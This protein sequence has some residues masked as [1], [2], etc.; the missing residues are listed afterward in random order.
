MNNTTDEYRFPFYVRLLFWPL[1]IFF[2]LLYHQFAWTYDWVA[3]IVSLGLWQSWVLS[4]THYLEGDCIL[5]LGSGPGHL[6]RAL[7]G[8]ESKSASIFGLDASPQ[9]GR[10]AWKNLKRAEIFPN[11]INGNVRNLPFPSHT[12]HSVAAT[13]PTEYIFHST[14]LAEIY[15]VLK[16]GGRMVVLTSAFITGRRRQERSAAW[17]FRVTGQSSP[18][19]RRLL[20]PAR[21]AGFHVKVEEIQL[22]T[23]VL[24][25]LIAEKSQEP[26]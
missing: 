13:F 17:L 21:Q 23:S 24:M 11:L 1:R 14:T 19:E 7:W 6:Q 26:V 22:K 25:L 5:E 8:K 16:P 18:L 10:I 2:Y 15:R 20:S 3:A 4:I 12:F 9:M